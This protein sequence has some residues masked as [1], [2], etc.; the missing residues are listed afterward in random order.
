MKT[1]QAKKI[2]PGLFEKNKKHLSKT[3]QP[4]ALL[5]KWEEKVN[6]GHAP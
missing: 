6:E 1:K 3:G 4:F 2:L 5:S